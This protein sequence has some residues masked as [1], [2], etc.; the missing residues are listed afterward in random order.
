[1]RRLTAP[2][3]RSLLALSTVLNREL[4]V[5]EGLAEAEHVVSFGAQHGSLA[6]ETRSGGALDPKERTLLRSFLELLGRDFHSIDDQRALRQKLQQL[7]E[8]NARL[9]AKNVALAESSSRDSLTGL[10]NRFYLLDKIE[11]ELNRATRHGCPTS[12]LMIDIDHFKQ[13]NDSWGHPMGDHVLQT[14]GQVL[15]DSCR[16]YDIPGRLG[17][18]EFCVLLPETRVDNTSVVAERIRQRL[19]LTSLQVDANASIRVT[20]SIG[21]AGMGDQTDES[22][23]SATSL[24]DRADKAL[25]AAKRGGRNRVE[26]WDPATPSN[27]SRPHISH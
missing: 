4:K 25:Y 8:D 1:M 14:V 9:V 21:V 23:W 5:S 20:A 24:I 27:S 10:Y 2:F 3:S 11:S 6:I 13:V 17:G 7:E 19:E 15:R 16:V 22:L 18:E 26:L 12:L